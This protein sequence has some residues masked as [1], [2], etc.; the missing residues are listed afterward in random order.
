MTP[1]E[2]REIYAEAISDLTT[3]FGAMRRKIEA[4]LITLLRRGARVGGSA[5]RISSPSCFTAVPRLQ[6]EAMTTR[7]VRLC[8][9]SLN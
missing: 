8:R 2:G 6:N 9:L 1:D 5:R 3:R 4:P 7:C